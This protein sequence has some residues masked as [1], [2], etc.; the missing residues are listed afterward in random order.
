M[1]HENDYL[2]NGKKGIAQGK[3]IHAI[4]IKNVFLKQIVFGESGDVS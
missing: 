2:W 1:T 4:I 3:L